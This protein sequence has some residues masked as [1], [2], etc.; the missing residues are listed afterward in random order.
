MFETT[1]RTREGRTTS[2]LDQFLKQTR[3]HDINDSTVYKAC[4]DRNLFC[5]LDERGVVFASRQVEI[6]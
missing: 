6:E 5:E 1:Q 2:I 3:S 4:I